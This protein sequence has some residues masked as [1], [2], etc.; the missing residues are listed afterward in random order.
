MRVKVQRRVSARG[1][2][3]YGIYI[4]RWWLPVWICVDYWLDEAVAIK[5]AEVIK[6]PNSVEIK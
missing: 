2:L 1:D 3:Q 6:H 4:K 5:K